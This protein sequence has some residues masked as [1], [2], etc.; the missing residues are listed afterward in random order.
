MDNQ[1]KRYIVHDTLEAYIEDL[2]TN[3]AY[4]FGWTT[5]SRITRSIAQEPI[6]AGIY[7]RTVAM[8][9]ADDGITFSVNTG[10]HYEDV[11]ELQFSDDFKDVTD[12]TV[13]E[14][15]ENPD[16]TF[17]TQEKTVSGQVMDLKPKNLPKAYRV[18][19][20]GI[21][22]DPD[23]GDEVADVYW[24]F[25]KAM[26]DGNLEEIFA[27]GANKTQTV[28]FTAMVPIGG[29]SYGKYAIIP[30]NQPETSL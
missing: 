14:I 25:D 3:K 29:D 15:V 26:P 21:A 24:I 27:A 20:R 17:T 23:T 6:K 30:K 12:L 22:Y 1:M 9:Q 19:L 11:M 10:V 28:N 18:Q 13:Q 5:E 4:F 16:G 2:K 8:L 7:N